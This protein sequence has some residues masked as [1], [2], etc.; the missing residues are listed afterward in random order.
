MYCKSASVLSPGLKEENNT[1][2]AFESGTRYLLADMGGG[3]VDVTVHEVRKDEKVR[4]LH[5]ATGGA[6]GGTYVDRN[7]V[8]L[9]KKIFGRDLIR[10]FRANHPCDW[11]DLV[12]VKF[13]SAKR[14][15]A[16]GEAVRV[17]LPYE[18]SSFVEDE[19][20]SV[21][22]HVTDFRNKD[23]KFGRGALTLNYPEVA[24][25]FN[26]VF[27]SITTHLETIFKKVENIEFVILV[28]GFATCQLLQE[29]VKAF[30]SRYDV[31]VLTA[32]ECSLAVVMGSVL[33]GHNPSMITSRRVKY[34]YGTCTC[35][36]FVT[37][38]DPDSRRIFDDDGEELCRG[39]FNVFAEINDEIEVGQEIVK[40]VFPVRACATRIN[41]SVYSSSSAGSRYITDCD[42]KKV[43]NIFL[44]MPNTEK[45]TD[46]R[47]YVRMCFGETEIQ[48]TSEDT[49]SGSKVE[50][51]VDLNFLLD[52]HK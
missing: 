34:S 10:K 41:V 4:E 40:S 2:G 19:G 1:S 11:T 42:V 25:L 39:R 32:C 23:I 48:V 33:F 31:R 7:F 37:G 29:H 16:T 17:L 24:K 27:S 8:R 52:D 35:M 22:K 18:F 3:T 43:A 21:K 6:W 47:A 50:R 46:R 51:Q 5:H 45:G 9:L 26:P 13:E 15:A 36:P 49:S 44:P 38:V 28:G 14:C 20:V 30:T 12:S